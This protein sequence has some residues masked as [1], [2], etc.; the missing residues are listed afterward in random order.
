MPDTERLRRLLQRIDGRSYKAYKDLEGPWQ[1]GDLLLHVDHAQGDPFAAPSRIRLASHNTLPPDI[2]ASPD[3]RLAAEDWLLRRFRPR[4]QKRGS[5]GSGLVRVYRPGPEVCE[6]SAVRILGPRIEVRFQVGLPASGRRILGR[7][8]EALLL[9][10]L[11]DAAKLIAPGPGLAEHVASVV[12]QRALRRALREHGLVAFVADGSVLPRR[13]GVDPSPLPDAVPFRSP[14]SLRTTLCGVPGMGVPA[15]VTLV[16]GGGFHGKSTLLQAI[17]H[18]H[19]DFI[20]GDGREQV[21]ADPTVVKVRAEDGRRVEGVDI[22]GFL[23][24]LPGGRSTRP[25]STDDASGSTS[26]AAAIAEA[27]EAGSSLPPARRRHQRH[28]PAGAGRA[29]AS[30]HRP[31]PRA[32]HTLRGARA[33]AVR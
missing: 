11:L 28:Q 20:P 14:D 26:Q 29:H 21:V 1:L 8:A 17:Q 9:G 16:V 24:Q 7:Q 22:S 12:H 18:G 3:H 5:G 23:G 32:H 19:L 2:L 10:D 4:D 33:P 25:F 13:S 30:A 6:R 15:G 31:R 27:L